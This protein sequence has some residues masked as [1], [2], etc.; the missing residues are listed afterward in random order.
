MSFIDVEVEYHK[1]YVL[2][3]PNKPEEG[4]K[5]VCRTVLSL[6]TALPHS[7][8]YVLSVHPKLEMFGFSSPYLSKDFQKV[9][10]AKK[11]AEGTCE[12]ISTVLTE[13]NVQQFTTLHYSIYQG[14]EKLI[15]Q[16]WLTIEHPQ[17]SMY[18]SGWTFSILLVVKPDRYSKE[19]LSC[20]EYDQK[21]CRYYIKLTEP[22]PSKL[23]EK[24]V[25]CIE[26]LEKRQQQIN[27]CSID[28]SELAIEVRQ[29]R[30]DSGTNRI[31]F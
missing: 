14:L 2:N 4:G 27:S 12:V 18:P 13:L 19:V 30:Y 21:R 8:C 15:P 31:F 23:M 5:D 7:V 11:W 29:A 25:A 24:A 3:N 26:G 22:T 10:D 6:T 20:W 9:S 28:M 1:V 17:V 16:F